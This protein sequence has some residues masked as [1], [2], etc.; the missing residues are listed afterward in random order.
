MVAIRQ[1]ESFVELRLQG[2]GSPELVSIVAELIVAALLAVSH[3]TGQSTLRPCDHRGARGERFDERQ[4]EW[5]V[6]LD[7]HQKRH[8]PGE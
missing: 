1:F 7:R 5:L 3:E 2:L 6:P 8:R 4:P